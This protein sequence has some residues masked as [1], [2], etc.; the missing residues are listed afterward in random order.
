MRPSSFALLITALLCAA[1]SHAVIT[2]QTGESY[3]AFQGEATDAILNPD[4]ANDVQ[5]SAQTGSAESPAQV[6]EPVD[7]DD[8]ID[9]IALKATPNPHKQTSDTALQESIAVYRIVFNQAGTYRLYLRARNNGTPD[10]GSTD[11]CW[12]QSSI[13]EANP[14]VSQSVDRTGLYAW[15]GSQSYTITSGQLGNELEL[16]IGVRENDLHLDALVLSTDTGLNS[17]EL[18]EL[19][20]EGG[21]GTI[22]PT[23]TPGADGVATVAEFNQA[24]ANASPGDTITLRSG[25]W[26]NADLVF[27]GKRSKNG[28]GG[29]AGNPITLKAENGGDVWLTGTS[30][31]RIAGQY[32]VV[33]GIV[34][35]N[36]YSTGSD[37]VQF[38]NGSSNLATNCRMTNCA[39]ID[40]NPASASTSYK[41][42]SVYGTDNRVDHCWFSGM[43]HAGVQL[44]VWPAA[45]GPPNNTRIDYNYFG[46]RTLGTGNGFETIRIGTSDVSQ[47]ESNALVEYNYFVNCDG[48]IETISNKSVGN[49]YRGNTFVDCRGQLT[50]RHGA[51]CVVDGNFFLGSGKTNS[52]GVRLIGPGHIVTNN[53]FEGLSGTNFYAALAMMNGVPNSPL[54]RYLRVEDC[55]VAFNTFVNCAQ[56]FAIGIESSDGDTTLPPQ[57]NTI[58]N[59]LVLSN[60]NTIFNIINA[61]VNM[62]YEGNIMD[63]GT[64]GISPTPAGITLASPMLA[65]AA[66]GLYRPTTG[67]PAIDGAVGSYPGV[68]DDMDGQARSDGSKDAGADE[69][70]TGAI[71]RK[72]LTPSDVGP[73]W[74]R[75]AVAILLDEWRVY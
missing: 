16:R 19:F 74:M 58:A 18:D 50:L 30:T 13:G 5:G 25:A 32:M 75:T 45:G 48:E 14:S 34:F 46:D 62:T 35:R 65:P 51:N 68:T 66:D 3:V 24:L 22:D 40:F 53:Y 37:V 33:D 43:N 70:T 9:D 11:S 4:A 17:G 42:V 29:T 57:N 10:N 20:G 38:R 27:D 52:S 2:Q 44:T 39:M 26:P 31:L 59:N 63:G 71:V 15:R 47:Q 21:G 72:P 49:V 56:T 64:L 7:D 67:S 41:W 69:V 8:A 12:V 54:N 60:G 23:P 55:T 6:W 1:Q 61:P 73:N 28:S 36:G